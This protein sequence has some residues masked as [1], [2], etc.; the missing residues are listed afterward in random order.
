MVEYADAGI[1]YVAYQRSDWDQLGS[2]MPFRSTKPRKRVSRGSHALAWTL[3]SLMN[4]NRFYRSDQGKT[5]G[6]PG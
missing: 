1:R 6:S 3:P 4:R 5:L 2:P